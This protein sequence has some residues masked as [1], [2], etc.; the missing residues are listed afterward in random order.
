M[1]S[2]SP[3]GEMKDVKNFA[4]CLMSTSKRPRTETEN[5]P[6]GAHAEGIGTIASLG[7]NAINTTNI[8]TGP[9]YFNR[10]PTEDKAT[11]PII[12]DE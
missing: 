2:A 9:V 1:D 4:S 6:E 5:K 10:V 8:F 12:W 11:D 3:S 7:D